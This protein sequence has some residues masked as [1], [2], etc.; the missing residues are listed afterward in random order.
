MLLNYYMGQTVINQ[1]KMDTI[2]SPVQNLLTNFKLNPSIF[3]YVED[4]IRNGSQ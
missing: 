3:L 2:T 1:P 4:R